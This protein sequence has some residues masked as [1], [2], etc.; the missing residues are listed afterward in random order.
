MVYHLAQSKRYREFPDGAIDMSAVNITSTVEILGWSLKNSVKKFIYTS[1]ANVFK[2][3]TCKIKSTHPCE[4]KSMYS[5]TKLSAEFI[6]KQY[7]EYFQIIILRLFTIYGPKQRNMLIPT[8]IEKVSLGQEIFLAN[9]V[10]IYLTPLFI[11]DC[12][13]ALLKLVDLN[14]SKTILYNLAGSEIIDL[15]EILDILEGFLNKKSNRINTNEEPLY[16]TGSNDRISHN[17]LYQPKINIYEGLKK[18]VKEYFK[19]V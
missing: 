3:S 1:T 4:P 12:I 13:E 10:G 2:K 6:I 18:T 16:I 8:L 7:E 14:R 9:G 11:S 19:N 17:I 15:S 5:A